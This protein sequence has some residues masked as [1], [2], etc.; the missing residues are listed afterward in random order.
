MQ[1]AGV[2]TLTA[3]AVVILAS[4]PSSRAQFD[5]P[6]KPIEGK[7]EPRPL[8]SHFFVP[9]D[10]RGSAEMQTV[11]GN[12][13]AYTIKRGDTFL[14][15]SRKFDVGYNALVAAH[16]ELDPWVPQP[17]TTIV[18]PTEWVLPKGPHKG[19]VLNIPEMRIYYYVP[20]PRRGAESS[21]VITYPVGLGRRDWQTPQGSFRIRGKTRNPTWVI[22]E[23]IR[24]ER[25]NETG[26]TDSFI[27]GGDPQNPLGHYRIE[28]TLPS[29][30]IHGTN[31]N[32]GI[33]MQV[34]HGCVRMFP[35][36]IK[37]FFP[38]VAVGSEGHFSYQPVKVGVRGGRVIVEVHTDIYGV[39]PWPWMQ[40][41]ER[42]SEM[43]LSGFVDPELLE[44]AVEAH[45]GVPTDVS[46]VDWPVEKL[47]KRITPEEFDD[48]GNLI[49][50]VD[51]DRPAVKDAG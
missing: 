8:V 42:I 34:S 21:T 13:Q 16:P 36:D 28:L 35:E 25:Y 5:E 41:Q 29:Y 27:R 7:I 46:Y 48:K 44:A 38:V 19:L 2:W 43:G 11:I 23:S 31:K 45:S 12:S 10:K 18:I 30:A 33:G 20:S 39:S 26:A 17:G 15:I 1:R 47:D 40:A 4:P 9:A 14:E 37:A 6:G 51:K 32:W 3:A 24:E 50:R 49:R 22:P